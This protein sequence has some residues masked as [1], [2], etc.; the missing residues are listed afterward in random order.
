MSRTRLA[1]SARRGIALR[2]GCSAGVVRQPI[3]GAGRVCRGL[4]DGDP[5]AVRGVM[6]G[7]EARRVFAFS[8]GSYD[9][10]SGGIVFDFGGGAVVLLLR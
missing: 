9:A 4:G 1:V 2:L 10:V 7:I 3:R 5:G 6:P 8:D